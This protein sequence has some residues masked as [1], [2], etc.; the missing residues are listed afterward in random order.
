MKIGFYEVFEMVG[1]DDQ[2]NGGLDLTGIPTTASKIAPLFFCE[3]RKYIFCE[4][5][6]C[7]VN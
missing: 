5:I 6:L 2:R 1:F 7:K 4:H 3:E